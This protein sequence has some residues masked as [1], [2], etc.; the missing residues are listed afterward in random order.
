MTDCIYAAVSHP[1]KRRNWRWTIPAI[2]IGGAILGGIAVVVD[3]QPEPVTCEPGSRPVAIVQPAT[4]DTYLRPVCL[5]D[6]VVWTTRGYD[7]LGA[8]SR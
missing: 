1:P 3:H 8:P 4:S 2:V 7:P 6:K 5:P